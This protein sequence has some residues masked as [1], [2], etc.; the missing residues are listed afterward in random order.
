MG[1]KRKK[2]IAGI[3]VVLAVVVVTVTAVLVA[4]RSA[5]PDVVGTYISQDGNSTSIE[6]RVRVR[7][8]YGLR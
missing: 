7:R 4:N 8:L 3:V 1:H 5:K 6:T 2:T